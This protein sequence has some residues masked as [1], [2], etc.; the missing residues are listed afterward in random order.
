MSVF[1]HRREERLHRL[2]VVARGDPDVVDAGAGREW[3]LRRIQSPRVL[4]ESKEGD[5]LFR[6]ALLRLGR[7]ASAQEGIV[8]AVVPQLRDQGDQLGLE[9]CEGLTHRGSA[10]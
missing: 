3:M 1:V 6:E 9:L 10:G 2:R 5:D 7:E 4:A 8:N